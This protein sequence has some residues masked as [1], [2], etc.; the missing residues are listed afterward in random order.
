MLVQKKRVQWVIA[1]KKKLHKKICRI[2]SQE[3]KI[4]FYAQFFFSYQKK[5]ASQKNDILIFLIKKKASP[6]VTISNYKKK[7]KKKKKNLY[8]K[9]FTFLFAFQLINFS[10]FYIYKKNCLFLLPYISTI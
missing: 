3:K 4:N 5:S 6:C 9:F 8:K 10:T 1:F 2:I 7:N